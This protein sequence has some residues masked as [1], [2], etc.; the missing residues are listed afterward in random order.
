VGLGAA[1]VRTAAMIIVMTMGL[2]TVGHRRSNAGAHT[3]DR[4]TIGPISPT[5]G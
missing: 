1:V 5:H 2:G 3:R 4:R